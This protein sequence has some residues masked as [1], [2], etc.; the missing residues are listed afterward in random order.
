MVTSL[1]VISYDEFMKMDLRVCR[2]VRAERIPGRSKL[3]KLAVDVGEDKLRTLV[4]GAA[5]YYPPE[6]FIGKNFVLVANLMPKRIAGV[7]SMGMLLAADF[8]GKPYWLLVDESVP[9]GT[10]IR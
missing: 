2:V 3:L 7:E 1:S 5:R 4:A 8:K 9:P 6:Y 10:K